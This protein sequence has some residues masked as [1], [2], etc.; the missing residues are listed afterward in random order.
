MPKKALANKRTYARFLKHQTKLEASVKQIMETWTSLNY[1]KLHQIY[2]ITF[3]ETTLVVNYNTVTELAGGSLK[4]EC[5]RDLRLQ[6]SLLFDKNWQL[7]LP[8]SN[9]AMQTKL[10]NFNSKYPLKEFGIAATGPSKT[11]QGHP[12]ILV[13]LAQK[14]KHKIPVVFEGLPVLVERTGK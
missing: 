6:T 14:S 1:L 11:D 12:C 13:Q 9:E 4:F 2:N 8:L 10:K 7:K 3:S 5:R